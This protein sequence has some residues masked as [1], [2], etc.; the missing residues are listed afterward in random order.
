MSQN[1]RHAKIG[2][3]E[4]IL[5]ISSSTL[6]DMA[7]QQW[8]EEERERAFIGHARWNQLWTMGD[9][10]NLLHY[11][12]N[13]S[14]CARYWVL[15]IDFDYNIQGGCA[16]DYGLTDFC[17][18]FDVDYVHTCTT[19]L[20]ILPNMFSGETMIVDCIF[21]GSCEHRWFYIERFTWYRDKYD[22]AFEVV[23]NSIYNLIS[24]SIDVNC[25]TKNLKTRRW[26]KLLVNLLVYWGKVNSRGRK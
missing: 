5:N 16:N 24:L 18:Y 25:R 12:F 22:I 13:A 10:T 8:E 11:F 23:F 17:V 6:V 14:T 4:N 19:K 20:P 3:L 1:A 15:I 2:M 7:S 21:L 26:K 9:A